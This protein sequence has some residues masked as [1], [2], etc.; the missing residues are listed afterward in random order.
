MWERTLK[1]LIRGMR[2]N[3]K[4][5][6]K[7]IAAAIDEIRDE[8]KSKD[9]EL[10][11]AAVLKL[12]Y[13]EMLG[14]DMSWASFHVLEVMS[15]TRIHHKAVGYLAA[16]Q[17]FTPATD[18]LMLTT[19]LLKKDL[20]STPVEIAVTLTGVSQFMTQELALDIGQ[21]INVL[22]T[23]SRAAVRKRAVLL[24]F[25]ALQ[26]NPDALSV[27]YPKLRDKLDDP[28]PSVVGATVSVLCELARQ[29]A[30]VPEL[31]PM[32]PQLF[33]LLTTSTNNWMLIKV[34]KLFGALTPHE[35]RLAKKLQSPMNELINTTPAI[36]LLYECVRTCIVGKIFGGAL[37]QTCVRKLGSFLEDN[38]QNLRYIALLG[39]VKIVP[40]HPELVAQHTTTILQS[41]D[42]RD[43]SIRMRAL[44]L[45]TEM[46]NEDNIQS[47]VQHLLSQLAPSTSAS[48]ASTTASETLQ[49]ALTSGASA[50]LPAPAMSRAY[51]L[52]LAQKIMSILSFDSY[53]RVPD[54]QWAISVLIDLAYVARAPIG[55]QVRDALIGVCLRVY[56]VRSYAANLMSRVLAD[57]SA[58]LGDSDGS[59]SCSEV[60]W[61]AAW[62][63]GEYADMNSS[64]SHRILEHLLYQP[65]IALL[66]T[67]TQAVFL[68]AIPKILGR[69]LA[70]LSEA[71]NDDAYLELTRR[72]VND[73]IVCAEAF[74]TSDDCEVQERAANI[75]N[76][77]S[78]LRADLAAHTPV[79]P[80][81][82][83]F[84][85]ATM[86]LDP[87]AYPFA[88][89]E[90]DD[91]DPEL[92]QNLKFPKSLLLLNPLFSSV[93]GRTA[94]HPVP[95]PVGLDLDAW[96]VPPPKPA[97]DT[98]GVPKPKS[99]KS[100]GKERAATGD[101][102]GTTKPK[103]KKKKVDGVIVA[104]PVHVESPAAPAETPE[105]AAERERR[106]AERMERLRDD[107]FYLFDNKS[108][109]PPPAPTRAHEDIDSIPI[110]K[111]DLPSFSAPVPITS[112][113]RTPSLTP[114]SSLRAASP[115]PSSNIPVSNEPEDDQPSSVP[116]PIKVVRAKKKKTGL[117]RKK[118]VEVAQTEEP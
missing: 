48:A 57:A 105:D 81:V 98:Y 16:S 114:A 96:F 21:D 84:K 45:I 30:I 70:A 86:D 60:L 1:D 116:D 109:P 52:T 93:I 40:S 85:P 91:D 83:R 43:I 99:K 103:K 69:W 27:A 61:A 110:V 33:H 75:F 80:P 34:I 28:D 41:V 79:S 38:D 47:V 11:A 18:V 100:K 68:S 82:A 73:C 13:L 67:G 49:N 3:K 63:V 62:I 42:D 111:L 55:A 92:A 32:A 12:T 88:D 102:T 56:S 23:H 58:F 94:A 7:F 112:A 101:D 35:P 22:L 118:T 10:K 64:A 17:S 9:M 51:R 39:L 44:D 95:I 104:E 15:S 8:V 72:V 46:V 14:Y 76:L 31:L 37:A 74:V 87:A 4:D 29:P 59:D 89:S 71:W 90:K 77:L 117:S 20:T 53:S 115:A 97:E 65:T 107:P 106:K 5:E 19:N 108:K 50:P 25:K 54:M 78:F 66:P 36:S 24:L 113:A 26:A 6:A 2:A